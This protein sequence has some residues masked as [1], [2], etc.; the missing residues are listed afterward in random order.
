MEAGSKKLDVAALMR[1]VLAE[2]Q[3]GEDIDAALERVT[4]REFP[5]NPKI[6][7]VIQQHFKLQQDRLGHSRQQAAEFLAKS[8]AFLSFDSKGDPF[9]EAVIFETKSFG[10]LPE[11]TRSE[12]LEKM[13]QAI[14]EG[15]STPFIRTDVKIPGLEGLSEENRAE[16]LEQIKQAF[17]EGKPIPERI[18]T[19][20]IEVKG[21]SFLTLVLFLA[22]LGVLILAYV[23]SRH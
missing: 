5:E 23:L 8:S 16:I 7:H 14:M 15:K 13:R 18:V 2:Q 19:R 17:Q 4:A 11:E 12:V 10:N 21:S 20:R 3:P 6:V 22:V 1:Q 9:L